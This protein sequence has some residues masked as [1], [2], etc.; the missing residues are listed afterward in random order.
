MVE[1]GS[2]ASSGTLI[3]LVSQR[4]MHPDYSDYCAAYIVE[5]GNNAIKGRTKRTCLRWEM[6][7]TGIFSHE[8]AIDLQNVRTND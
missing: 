2:S 7:G 8:V 3:E 1:V 5:H 6:L 4:S